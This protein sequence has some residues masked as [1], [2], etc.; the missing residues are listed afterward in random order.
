MKYAKAFDK[1]PDAVPEFTVILTII[2]QGFNAGSPRQG[3]A[4]LGPVNLFPG[5]I[6]DYRHNNF[7]CTQ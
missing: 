1:S 6:E 4:V 3:N 2:D 5:R 7:M